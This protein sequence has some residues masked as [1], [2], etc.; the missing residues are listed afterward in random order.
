MQKK[1]TPLVYPKTV[2]SKMFLQMVSLGPYLASFTVHLLSDNAGEAWDEK[3]SEFSEQKPQLA[4]AV[5]II[6][7][8][9]SFRNHGHFSAEIQLSCNSQLNPIF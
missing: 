4:R 7:F 9:S 5:G 6:R 2:P 8:F 3:S 1:L